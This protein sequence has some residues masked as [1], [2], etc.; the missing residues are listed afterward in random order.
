MGSLAGMLTVEVENIWT[1]LPF[2]M[3]RSPSCWP[4]LSTITTAEKMSSM[5]WGCLEHI[6]RLWT[7]RSWRGYKYQASNDQSWW[8]GEMKWEGSEYKELDIEN[9]EVTKHTQK[10]R[11]HQTLK[12]GGYNNNLGR[13]SPWWRGRQEGEMLR[14]YN[15]MQP[16]GGAL[17][18]SSNRSWP[19]RSF[20]WLSKEGLGDHIGGRSVRVKLQGKKRKSSVVFLLCDFTILVQ[21]LKRCRATWKY[22]QTRN[23]NQIQINVAFELQ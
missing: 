6:M 20:N 16:V 13:R 9:G 4:T 1:T 10:W 8:T 7:G 19:R 11:I 5:Q 23:I 3:R 17:I 15:N 12:R 18:F 21:C 14:L 2:K 22:S